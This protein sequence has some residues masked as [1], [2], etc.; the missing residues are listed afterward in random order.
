MLKK[1]T[2]SIFKLFG[3]EM[4][5]AEKRKNTYVSRSAWEY[6]SLYVMPN[7]G[8]TDRVIDIGCG[9]APSPIASVLTD[10]FPDESIHRARPVV[11][12]RPLI[13][14]SANRMPIRDK[15]FDLSICS[16]VLEHVPDP[17]SA[18]SEI[19]RISKKGYLETPAYGKDV[20]VGT[21]HQHIWQVVN[22]NGQFHFFPYTQR[23]H[24][25]HANSSFMSIWCQDEYHPWQPFF[26]ERQDIFNA[27]QFWENS[28]NVC[29]HEIQFCK[30]RQAVSEWQPI[31]TERLPSTPSALSQEEIALLESCLISPDGGGAMRYLNGEFVDATGRIK[32][33]VRGK[34]IYFEMAPLVE[35]I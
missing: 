21:G 15:F 20:L 23:Q 8:G 30:E 6:Q 2:N 14:C 13:V 25:A 29:V 17:A 7:F 32:Y 11:E 28:P 4:R 12:D 34:R 19:G 9:A 35:L 33:P 27:I 22:D 24:Q 5:R 31:A 26:W 3:L 10:F 18:A 16:H 1:F